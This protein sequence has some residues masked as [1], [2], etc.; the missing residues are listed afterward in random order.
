[1]LQGGTIF[2]GRRAGTERRLLLRHVMAC[3]AS[4]VPCCEDY[5]ALF[6]N[7]Y[8][9]MFVYQWLFALINNLKTFL[10]YLSSSFGFSSLSISATFGFFPPP[11]FPSPFFP[12][13][14]FPLSS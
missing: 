10:N 9:D 7:Y 4:M 2:T 8:S 14:F 11:F 3:T 1:M 5:L 6:F 13:A 12:P